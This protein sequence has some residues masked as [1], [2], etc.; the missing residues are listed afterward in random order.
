[1][2]LA[3]VGDVNTSRPGLLDFTGKAKWWVDWWSSHA[4]GCY[5]LHT[6][7]SILQSTPGM[8]GIQSKVLLR[9]TQWQP[10]SRSSSRRVWY[11]FSKVVRLSST[12]HRSLTML[13]GMM[14]KVISNPS[15]RQETLHE[16]T[17]YRLDNNNINMSLTVLVRVVCKPVTFRNSGMLHT[18]PFFNN[19]ARLNHYYTMTSI[20]FEQWTA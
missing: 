11:L 8:R 15:R 6:S 2:Q 3:T 17:N 5:D 10:T 18:N 20:S 9:K 14:H 7:F 19:C 12:S 13:E 1:M 16:R 4:C